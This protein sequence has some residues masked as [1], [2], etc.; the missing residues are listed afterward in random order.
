[1]A[2]RASSPGRTAC[3][4]LGVCLVALALSPPVDGWADDDF[5]GHMAQHLL[6]GMYAPLFL[7]L[8]APVTLLL[9]TAPRSVG[10]RVGR[11]LRTRFVRTLSHPVTALALSAGGTVVVYA[12]PLYAASTRNET[13]HVLVH[14]HFLLAGCLFARAVAGPDPDPH[15]APVIVRLVVLGAGIA[16]HATLA[17][18]MYAG[19]LDLPGDP[20]RIRG[21]AELMYY[22][23]DI[24]ELLLA[25]AVL[26]T[27][28]PARRP[29]RRLSTG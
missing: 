10:R 3:L 16:V 28:R 4:L 1:M 29:A 12:T 25:L 13:L 9:R 2:G 17:Q 24:G 14:A 15:R 7:V 11:L 21:G 5:R 18:V 19:L 6:L 26:T 27:W 20:G 23:G 8:G 22:G